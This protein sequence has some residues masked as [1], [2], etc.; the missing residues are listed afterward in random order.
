M[1]R[2]LITGKAVVLRQILI[3]AIDAGLVAR[4]LGDAGSEIVAL[5]CRSP[6]CGRGRRSDGIGWSPFLHPAT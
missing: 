4:R 2:V 5:L 1:K 3:G 6:L